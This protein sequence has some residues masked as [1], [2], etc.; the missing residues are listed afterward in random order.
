MWCCVTPAWLDKIMGT[1]YLKSIEEVA[2]FIAA[3][4]NENG[5]MKF[6]VRF[7]CNGSG[8]AITFN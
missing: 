4:Q 7:S 8:Y 3:Y 1:I 5:Q 2:A 6:D